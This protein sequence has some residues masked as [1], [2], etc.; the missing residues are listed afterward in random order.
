[1]TT[2]GRLVGKV[3]LVTGA[4]S[5]RGLG[6][7]I[8]RRFAEEGAIVY[9][10]DVDESG[11]VARAAE[12]GRGAKAFRQDVT[13]ESEWHAALRKITAAEGR[14]DILVNN[15]GVAILK[16]LAEFT[17]AD[18][19]RQME[20]NLTSMFLGTRLALDSMRAAKNGG[21]IINMSSVAGIIGI[22]GVSAYAASKGGGRAFSK[23]A[24]LEAAP[25]SIRVNTIHPGMI[26]TGMQEVALKDNAE[27]YKILE[28]GIP[29]RRMGQPIDVANAAL[30]LACDEGRYI[31][32][33]ELVVDGGMTAQ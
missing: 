4:G 5:V 14:L 33:A 24:A 9:M 30:F 16:P 20:V 2:A 3:A 11:V 19:T 18:Y 6:D 26:L 28:G 32:G 27:Q 8:A 15:A 1:M 12:I 10:T 22:P 21:S 7:A 31:T 25:D 23:V 13:S 17:L 29:L